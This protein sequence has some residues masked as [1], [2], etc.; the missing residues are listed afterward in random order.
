MTDSTKPTRLARLLVLLAALVAAP[1]ALAGGGQE[2]VPVLMY[3]HLV[4]EAPR[5]DSELHVDCFRRQMDY[6]HEQ[7]FV[8]LSLEQFRQHHAAG[9]FPERSLLITFDDGYRSFLEHAYPVLRGYGFSSV[10]FPVVALRPGLQRVIVWADHLSFHEIRRMSNDGG[11]LEVGSHSYDLHHETEDGIAAIL[12]QPH[13][14]EAERRSRVYDDLL[15]SRLILDH[16]VDTDVVAL[17][18]PYGVYDPVSVDIATELGFS[19]LFT[20]DEGYVTR[21]TPLTAIP[22]FNVAAHGPACF[23]AIVNLRACPGH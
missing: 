9:W 18:W 22:R 10:M 5:A 20:T 2:A 13:E 19:L 12:R 14:S 8:T 21:D 3:H 6:L 17:A 11:L 4:T 1:A 7:G 23:E 15:T 16:Q